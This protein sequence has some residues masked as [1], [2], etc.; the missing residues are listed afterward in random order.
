MK[1]LLFLSMISLFGIDAFGQNVNELDRPANIDWSEDS[2]EI[3]TIDDIVKT[4]QGLTSNQFEES[5]FQ[6]VWSR[7]GYLN[8]SYN[9]FTLTPDEKVPTGVSGLNGGYVPE[10]KS[11]WGASLQVGRGYKLHKKPIANILQFYIDYRYIDLNVNFIE[12]ENNGKDL[13]DTSVKINDKRFYTPWNLEK[14]D[15]NYG[16]ALGPSITIAPF[17]TM[18]SKG[19]H[20]L[21]LNAWYQIGYHASLL[22]M[23]NDEAADANPEKT[24]Y[25]KEDKVREGIKLDLG[26]GMTNAFGFSLTWKFIGVGYEH[27]SAKLEYQTLDKDTY[28]DDKYKFKSTTNRVFLQFRLK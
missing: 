16:M 1:K 7:K 3:V 24:S 2:T 8:L 23:K 27:R 13:Y 12:H 21:H 18:S 19:L 20:H 26:H 11:K 10:F 28:V 5:H 14:Y 6:D 15:I 9:N 17:N 4:Q 25:G 22:L